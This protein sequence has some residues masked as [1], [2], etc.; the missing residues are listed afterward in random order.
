MFGKTGI[1]GQEYG[2]KNYAGSIVSR[3]EIYRCNG[4]RPT[5]AKGYE[6]YQAS[7]K[8]GTYKKIATTTS[9]NYKIKTTSKKSVYYKVR[10]Y[11]TTQGVR[12]CGK[13][14]GSVAVKR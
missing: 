14:S 5:G 13:F 2:K 1:R 7:S 8:N 11:K 3:S 6:I 10:A 12:I 4:G 9:A